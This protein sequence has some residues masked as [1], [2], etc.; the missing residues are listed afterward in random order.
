MYRILVT[1]EGDWYRLNKH[2]EISTYMYDSK[3]IMAHQ[4][5]KE[6]R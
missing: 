6:R 4:V 2:D 1:R 5:G 3:K